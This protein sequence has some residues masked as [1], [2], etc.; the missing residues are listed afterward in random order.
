MTKEQRLK[1][2]AIDAYM[3]LRTTQLT[4]PNTHRSGRVQKSTK[5]AVVAKPSPWA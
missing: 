2:S 5:A 1:R 4:V 3:Q